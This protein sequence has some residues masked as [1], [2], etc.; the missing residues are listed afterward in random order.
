[1]LETIA[2]E[3]FSGTAGY[4]VDDIYRTL[5]QLLGPKQ[6]VTWPADTPG[7]VNFGG[8]KPI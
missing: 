1:V 2:F 6:F 3:E 4:F 8:E 7:A 5:H